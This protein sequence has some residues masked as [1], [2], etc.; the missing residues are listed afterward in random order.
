[1]PTVP[2]STSEAET[3]TSR[4]PVLERLGPRPKSDIENDVRIIVPENLCFPKIANVC[5]GA[6][7]GV[8]LDLKALALR[9]RNTAYNPRRFNALFMRLRSPQVTASLFVTGK[10]NVS[11]AR[12]E[13]EARLAIRKLAKKVKK[14]GY[15]EARKSSTVIHCMIAMFQ[16]P[17][18]IRLERVAAAHCLFCSY[19]PELFPALIYKMMSPK[20]TLMIYING[21]VNIMG[22]KHRSDA[23]DAFRKI[24]PVLK[25]CEKI[26]GSW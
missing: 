6:S 7:L 11:G 2:R 19:E 23:V 24:Y 4:T 21:K 12:T 5:A 15:P 22:V 26:D 13:G 9:A 1:M 8:R 17:F 10:L 25:N 14:M 16:V 18:Q 20:V 3:D